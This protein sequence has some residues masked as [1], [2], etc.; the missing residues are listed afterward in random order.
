[1]PFIVKRFDDKIYESEWVASLKRTYA[2]ISTCFNHNYDDEVFQR[3]ILAE[4]EIINHID[5]MVSEQ[6]LVMAKQALGNIRTHTEHF[7]DELMNSNLLQFRCS[8]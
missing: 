1:M 7:C 5:E 8:A 3:L 6:Q 4:Q 2:V